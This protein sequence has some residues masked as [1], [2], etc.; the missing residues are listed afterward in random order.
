VFPSNG[1][2]RDGV[3]HYLILISL[4][5]LPCYHLL[6]PL[7]RAQRLVIVTA[8]VYALIHGF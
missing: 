7:L 2:G 5:I 1:E 4:Y 3:L 6:F 8:F